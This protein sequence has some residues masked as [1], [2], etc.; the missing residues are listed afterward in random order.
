MLGGERIEGMRKCWQI[1]RSID[2][3]QPHSAPIKPKT[4]SAHLIAATELT[5][6]GV[7]SV[8][9]VLILM[10]FTMSR[11][12]KV[13]I[14]SVMWSKGLLVSRDKSSDPETL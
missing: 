9:Q 13:S 12:A 6:L 7:M 10:S 2:D 14:L 3:V 4:Y 8:A 1:R 5:A 11:H